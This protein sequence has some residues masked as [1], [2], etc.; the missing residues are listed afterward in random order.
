MADHFPFNENM[1]QFIF[2]VRDSGMFLPE[3]LVDSPSDLP[4]L[5]MI[6]GKLTTSSEMSLVVQSVIFEKN[7]WTI[8]QAHNWIADNEKSLFPRQQQIEG[9]AE[10]VMETLE[11]VEIFS[12]GTWHGDEWTEAHLDGVVKAFDETKKGFQPYLKLGHDPDQKLLQIDGFPAAGYAEKLY[13]VGG[14]L[15]ADIGS[16]PKK[17]FQLLKNKAYRKVSCEIY[18]NVKVNGKVY[19]RFISAISLLGADMPEVSCLDDV[20]SLYGISKTVKA[21]ESEG[22]KKTITYFQKEIEMPDNKDLI[23]AK[24]ALKVAEDKAKKLESDA[25]TFKKS[26]DELTE[27]KKFKKQAESDKLEADKKLAAVELDKTV[28]EMKG[29]TPGMKPFVIELLGDKK[30]YSVKEKK[31][32]KQDLLTEILKLHGKSFD[33]NFSEGSE[34]GEQ[35]KDKVAGQD[36]KIRKYMKENEGVGYGQAYVAVGI[37]DVAPTIKGE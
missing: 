10:D 35:G 29:V 19:D 2:V 4:G 8:E 22:S 16:V 3:S 23:E 11:G 31:Y 30:E 33:V 32:S 15:L 24:A 20:L 37:D 21:Y 9:S 27:L 5:L 1:T 12:V 13:R 25:K 6:M 28:G 34:E 17:I 14:K 18:F 36:A 26:D 7:S